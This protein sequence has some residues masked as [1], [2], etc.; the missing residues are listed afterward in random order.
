MNDARRIYNSTYGTIIKKVYDLNENEK[1][2]IGVYRVNGN[3]T[4]MVTANYI[5]PYYK[6]MLDNIIA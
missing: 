2:G 5:K 6:F 4:V 3:P 1:S